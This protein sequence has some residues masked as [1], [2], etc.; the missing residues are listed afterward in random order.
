MLSSFFMNM[1]ELYIPD[2]ANEENDIIINNTDDIDNRLP[3]EERLS[4]KN[5]ITKLFT[6][7]ESFV[8]YPFRVVYILTPIEEQS[9]SAAMFVS[10]PKKKFKRAVKRNL[11]RRRTK[12]AYRLNKNIIISDLKEK[13]Q[14]ISIA[15]IYLDKEIKNYKEIEKGMKDLLLRLKNKVINT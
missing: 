15:F 11:I 14:H 1:T 9:S 5:I 12:E 10:V 3:K 6:N 8:C 13:N 2:M 4:S 7:G